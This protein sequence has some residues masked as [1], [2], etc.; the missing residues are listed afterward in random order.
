MHRLTPL[1]ILTT[2]ALLAGCHDGPLFALKTINPVYRSQW[3]EDQKLGPTDV[4]RREELQRLVTSMPSLSDADQEY[5]LKHVEAL[6]E[7]DKNP[8]MRTLAIRALEG[9]RSQRVIDLCEKQLSDESIK[10]RMAVCDVLATRDEARSTQ[11]LGETIGSES[12]EDVQM[13]A[14]AA[15]GKHRSPEAAQALKASLRS[16][17]PAVR[18]AS[19]ESLGECTGKNLGEDP[20]VWVAYLDGKEVDEEKKS[21]TRQMRDLF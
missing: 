3:A 1:A 11:L 17:N 4:Q 14:I 5:W 21:L 20:Q 6:L 10:V 18:V 15:V 19:V 9:C 13:A 2:C 7:N 8:E 12:N 16:R